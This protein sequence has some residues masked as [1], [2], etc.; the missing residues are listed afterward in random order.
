MTI[1][2]TAVDV[3]YHQNYDQNKKENTKN[4]EFAHFSLSKSLKKSQKN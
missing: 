1:V 3:K 4:L 2:P